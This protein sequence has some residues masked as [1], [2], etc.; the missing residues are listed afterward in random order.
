MSATF[1]A[2]T[3]YWIYRLTLDQMRKMD[4]ENGELAAEAM[5]EGAFLG[6]YDDDPASDQEADELL[7]LRSSFGVQEQR[8]GVSR[9]HSSAS[10]L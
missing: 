9:R 8:P 2:C 5:E 6:P 3:G 10:D 7:G 1:S 4:R